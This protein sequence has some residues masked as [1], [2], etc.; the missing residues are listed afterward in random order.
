[1]ATGI[2]K[3]LLMPPIGMRRFLV[4]GANPLGDT[5]EASIPLQRR[6]GA[7]H[8]I[9]ALLRCA[10]AFDLT[11]KRSILKSLDSSTA[12]HVAQA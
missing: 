3:G 12:A 5:S 6:R 8:T 7:Q 1:M 2:H 4:P 11:S 9:Q 10:I